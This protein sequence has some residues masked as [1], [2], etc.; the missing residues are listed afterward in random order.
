MDKALVR[1]FDKIGFENKDAF[2]DVK[3]LKVVV[4]KKKESWDLYLNDN[5][6][7]EVEPLLNLI[8]LSKKGL[9]DVS[10][11][12]IIINYDKILDEDVINYFKYYLNILTNNNPSLI[13]LLDAVIRIND[14]E[15]D[16]IKDNSKK[17][18]KW[19]NSVGLN[20]YE[21][22][23]V[24]NTLKR[25]TIKKEIEENRDTVIV[26]KEPEFKV[27]VGEEIKT[28]KITPINEIL[29]EEN[30]VTLEAY[31]FGI[32][33]FVSNKSNFK[34]L[35]LKISDKT[36]SLLAK[37][38]SKDDDEF[39]K[40]KAGLKEGKWYKFRGYTKNDNFAKDLVLNIRDIEEIPSKTDKFKDD[41]E[42]K[43]VELHAHT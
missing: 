17:M 27:I 37:I 1:Y 43:R 25:E 16:L 41:A 5:N 6:V 14:I 30:N 19:F 34:I 24:V 33:E 21:I 4:N 32:E 28:K 36:D 11:I 29:G 40:Y 10:E 35:T 3:L 13:S 39:A 20:G 8:N 42:V 18:I 22:K 15:D 31:I 23:P 9:P 7:L 12:N 2:K 38:F 26:K